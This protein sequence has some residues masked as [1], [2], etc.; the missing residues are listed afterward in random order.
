V[1]D[2]VELVIQPL[3][4][5]QDENQNQNPA[6]ANNNN[7]NAVDDHLRAALD[8]YEDRAVGRA[9][10]AVLASRQACLDAHRWARITDQSPLLSRRAMNLAF[11]ESDMDPAMIS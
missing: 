9:R 8:R 4:T 11:D 10:P 7:N 3:I 2:L 1:L 5:S 6:A